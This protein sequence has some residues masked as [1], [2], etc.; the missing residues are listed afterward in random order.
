MVPYRVILGQLFL[1]N[2]TAIIDRVSVT[3]VPPCNDILQCM[4]SELA[5]SHLSCSFKVYVDY[6]LIN[7]KMLKDEFP[8]PVIEDRLEQLIEAKVFTK[9]VLKDAFFI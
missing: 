1:I 9:L 5:E 4:L 2:V 6:Q 8:L 3:I 7:R